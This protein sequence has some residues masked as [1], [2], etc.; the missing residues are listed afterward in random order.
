MRT[1]Y[2][3]VFLLR[4]LSTVLSTL[5]RDMFIETNFRVTHVCIY[6]PFFPVHQGR[7]GSPYI[8]HNIHELNKRKIHSGRAGKCFTASARSPV[9]LCGE[10]R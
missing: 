5:K 6:G 4:S 1:I 10:G 2:A 7:Q 3:L 8:I 9:V